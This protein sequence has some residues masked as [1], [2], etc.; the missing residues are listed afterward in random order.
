MSHV[1]IE[2]QWFFTDT[3][4]IETRRITFFTRGLYFNITELRK[5]LVN[6]PWNVGERTETLVDVIV[7][8]ILDDGIRD[9][10]AVAEDSLVV[11]VRRQV[12][13]YHLRVIPYAHLRGRHK[14]SNILPP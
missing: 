6:S 9:Q 7:L 14:C 2:K 11:V 8:R 10:F 3:V 13:V 5:N 1:W 4:F 12:A